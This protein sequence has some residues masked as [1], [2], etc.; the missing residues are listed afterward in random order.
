LGI[1]V[2]NYAAKAV[3]VRE[4][5]QASIHGPLEDLAMNSDWGDPREYD[6]T[7][8]KTGEKLDTEYSVMPSPAKA[9]TEEVP[10]E[11][12]EEAHKAYRKAH[13]NLEALFDGADPFDR[14]AGSEVDERS[15]KMMIEYSPKDFAA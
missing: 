13:I 9:V 3:E 15:E 5:T 14:S 1:A 2:Y 6:I 7:V 11:V 12:P 8:T 10:E 4:I